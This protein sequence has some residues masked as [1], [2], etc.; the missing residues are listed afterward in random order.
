MLY[1]VN[2]QQGQIY[3]NTTIDP[4][5]GEEVIEYTIKEPG[6][7]DQVIQKQVKNQKGNVEDDDAE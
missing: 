1:D 6:K 3:V 4:V 5:T 2:G 7:V